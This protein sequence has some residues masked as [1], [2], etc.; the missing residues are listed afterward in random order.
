MENGKKEYL[1]IDEYIGLFPEHIQKKLEELR[2][3]IKELVPQAQE[4][5]S[6]QMPTFFLNGN[7]VHFAGYSKHIGFYPG[8][9]G[10]DAFKSELSKYKY[11]MGSVQFPLED[12]INQRRI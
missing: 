9:S 3:V 10:I 12:F 4:K 5:I 6:W 8:A 11:A 7:L 1:S 2:N